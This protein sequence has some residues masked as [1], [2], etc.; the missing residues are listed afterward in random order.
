MLAVCRHVLWRRRLSTLWWSLGLAGFAA[1]L[2]VAY[3]TV[4]GNGELDQTFAGLPPGV[5]AALGLDPTNSLTSPIGYLNSQYFANVLPALFLIFALNLAAWTIAGDEANGTLELLLANPVTRLRVAA[6]RILALIILLA[7]LT[8]VAAAT[9]ALLA[10][11]VGLDR[12]VGPGGLIGA[13][14]ATALLAF[15]FAALAF[16][17]GAA[18]GSRSLAVSVAATLAVAGFVVEGLAAQVA[19]LRP[20]RALSPWHWALGNSPLRHGLDWQSGLLP[21]AASLIL[22]ALGAAIFSRR[23]LR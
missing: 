16:G 22:I 21:V 10:P 8:G 6:E 7:V 9:L 2:A 20:V 14:V 18:T 12:G 17:V 5:Q 4:R 1:L 15:C 23:D 11:G 19:P 13:T 3:P